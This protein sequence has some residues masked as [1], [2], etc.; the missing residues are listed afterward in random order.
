MLL[1]SASTRGCQAFSSGVHGGAAL[2]ILDYCWQRVAANSGHVGP[3]HA[4]HAIA[5]IISNIVIVAIA[6]IKVQDSSSLFPNAFSGTVGLQTF[7]ILLI[8]S[9]GTTA[10]ARCRRVKRATGVIESVF[11]EMWTLLLLLPLL[12]SCSYL[13]PTTTWWHLVNLIYII[14][15]VTVNMKLTVTRK[16]N[17]HRCWNCTP[18]LVRAPVRELFREILTLTGRQSP[19]CLNTLQDVNGNRLWERSTLSS[20][21][22]CLKFMSDKRVPQH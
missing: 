11:K 12:L 2:C 15:Q 13:W 10:L 17:Y 6:S 18:A 20:R 16:S 7:C 8:T 4:P 9:S 5:V 19:H 14:D 3:Y 1:S 22:L 21:S